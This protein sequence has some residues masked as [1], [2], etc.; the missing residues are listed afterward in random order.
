MASGLNNTSALLPFFLLSP[1]LFATYPRA[2]RQTW[3]PYIGRKL[4]GTRL[5]NK[6]WGKPAVRLTFDALTRAEV[7]F[8]LSW[9]GVVTFYTLNETTNVWGTYNG[10]FMATESL[11]QLEK[12][13]KLSAPY[14]NVSYDV[15]DLYATT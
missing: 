11:A 4:L 10:V 2:I 13:R 14:S 9:E 12:R 5:G 8:L 15:I 1:P 3:S 7:V 6:T